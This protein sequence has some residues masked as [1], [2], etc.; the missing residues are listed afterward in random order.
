MTYLDTKE[1]FDMLNLFKSGMI[2][3]LRIKNRIVMAPM[4]SRGLVELD[5]RLSQRLVDHFTRRAAGGA[6]LIITG[7][8]YVEVDIEPKLEGVFCTGTPRADSSL[9][10]ARFEELAMAVHAYGAKIAVQLTAGRGRISAAA[11]QNAGRVVAPSPV[12]AFWPPHKKARALTIAEIET[13]IQDFGIAA[14]M[15]K[16]AGIDAVE[17]HA[18]EG[19]LIDEFTTALWNQRSDKYGGDFESRLRF[20]L[21]IIDSIKSEAGA[22][23]PII[24]RF[25]ASHHLEG[26]RDIDE[27]LEMA[28][29][30]QQAGVSAFHVDAGCYETSYYA[31]P[32]IYMPPG[33]LLE[34]IVA[35]KKVVDIP[36][37]AVGK[38]G[39]PKLAEEVLSQGQADFVAIGRALLADPEWPLKV[40][41]GRLDDIRTCIGC[42]ECFRRLLENKYLSCAVNPAAGMEKELT[43]EPATKKKRVL[44]VGGGPGGMEAAIVSALRGHDVTLWEKEDK[45][46]G[47]LNPAAVPAFKNDLLAFK[48]YLINQVEKLGIKVE[49]QKEATPQLIREMSPDEL[50][51]ATGAA[52]MTVD[53]P[54]VSNDNVINSVDA[55]LG[56]KKVGDKVVVIGGSEVGCEVAI[57][58]AQQGKAVTIVEILQDILPGTIFM[59]KMMLQKMLAEA[60]VNLLTGTTVGEIKNDAVIVQN[61]NGQQTLGADTIILAVGREKRGALLG[62]LEGELTDIHVIGDCVEPR[63]IRS[64]MWEAYR[65]ARVI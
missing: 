17:L 4:G 58:L 12:P 57:W 14:R 19:Y 61:G 10:L 29:R 54:G 63:E 53:C 1:V 18:H 6:G 16:G 44:V 30:L 36:V 59:N 2:G 3:N 62:S 33:C 22:D 13:I 45:L 46:G 15:L 32:P 25:G 26:G 40:K 50:I 20:P 38:L 23:F 21:G 34:D 27:S 56:N 37:I 11:D 52:P 65:T 48:N 42:N 7:L 51:I 28:R 43:L 9:F 5:G 41:E 55:L 64:A 31:H 47:S 35:V 49:L 60:G 39:Y 24:Y 8:T